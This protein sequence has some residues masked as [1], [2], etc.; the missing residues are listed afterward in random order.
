M[1]K[2]QVILKGLPSLEADLSDLLRMDVKI[3]PHFAK[4]WEN[5][6]TTNIE[7]LD[8]L[9]IKLMF[10]PHIRLTVTEDDYTQFSAYSI[11][12]RTQRLDKRQLETLE[13]IFASNY[14]N[15]PDETIKFPVYFYDSGSMMEWVFT[16]SNLARIAYWYGGKKS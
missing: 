16:P 4:V 12:D 1:S 11:T 14:I 6:D 7:V 5:I 2:Y 10:G 8:N 3:S 15:Q 9:S 13:A